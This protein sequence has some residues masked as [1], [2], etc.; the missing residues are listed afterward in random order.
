MCRGAY[1]KAKEMGWLDKYTWLSHQK[2]QSEWDYESCKKEA[3]KYSSRN[4]FGK[5]SYGAYTQARKQGWLDEFYP[6]PL[7][8]VFDYDT[9]KQLSAKYNSVSELLANDR[10]LYETLRKKGWMDD[11]FPNE[12]KNT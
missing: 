8:R 6:V 7:R 5:H 2:L 1:D 10:S 4:E 12:R 9:C 11:F 3:M